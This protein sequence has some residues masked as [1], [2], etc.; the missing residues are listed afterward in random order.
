[1][2]LYNTES[3]LT[4]TTYIQISCVAGVLSGGVLGDWLAQRIRSGRFLIAVVGL[5]GCAPFAFL[6]LAAGSLANAKLSATAFGFFAGLFIANNSAKVV[7]F[8]ESVVPRPENRS[9]A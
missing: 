6:C 3:S 7:I 8:P 5:A 9:S 4:A 2:R 1:M